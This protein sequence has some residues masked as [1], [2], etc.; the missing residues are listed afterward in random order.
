MNG[1]TS[2]AAEREPSSSD[3]GVTPYPELP[4]FERHRTVLGLVEGD[5]ILDVGCYTGTFV[6]AAVLCF[7]HKTVLGIDYSAEHIRAAQ[8]LYPDMR[9]H[10]RAMSVYKLALGDASVD[11]ITLQETLEHLEGAALAVKE[12]N[13][14]LKLGGVLIVSVP[15][16]YYVGRATRF[17]QNE[18]GNAWQRWRG[19][20]QNLQPEILSLE[21]E[22][23]RH[24]Y[25]WTPQALLGL[26]T[27]N[28]FEYVVHCYENGMPDAFRRSVLRLL[29]FLGPTLI[30]KVRKIGPAPARLV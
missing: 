1:V 13:R 4:L 7:P 25:A 3:R 21:D 27:H 14:V 16:P 24:V 23:D 17:V 9:E 5:T 28:G 10:F 20:P 22:W 15:N 26:F 12:L 6:R 30:L 11:C 18:I 2:Y 29:P 8:L 19:R